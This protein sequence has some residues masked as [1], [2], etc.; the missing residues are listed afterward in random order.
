MSKKSIR[1]DKDMAIT[2]NDFV[3]ANDIKWCED[4]A[5]KYISRHTRKNGS[6]DIHKAIGFL[7][8]VLREQYGEG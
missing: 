2:T 6:E 8:K 7:K 4:N 5:I 3:I 1:Y